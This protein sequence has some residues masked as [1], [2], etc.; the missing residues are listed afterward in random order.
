MADR[1]CR[2]I[3]LSYSCLSLPSYEGRD[4]SLRS[5]LS[6]YAPARGL[7]LLRRN[8]WPLRRNES[9]LLRPVARPLRH[10]GQW[11]LYA[12]LDTLGFQQSRQSRHSLFCAD[13]GQV[14]VSSVTTV[15]VGNP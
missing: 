10:D 11:P 1:A 13:A 3:L 4:K 15:L 9:C 12:T 5:C 8:Q 7:Y 2:V 6:S 14:W